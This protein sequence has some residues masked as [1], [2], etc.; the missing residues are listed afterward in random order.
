[1]I[2]IVILGLLAIAILIVRDFF[3][4]VLPAFAAEYD[5]YV[6]Q[7]VH[8]LLILFIS[9]VAAYHL[10]LPNPAASTRLMQSVMLS[11]ILMLS[12]GVIA[13]IGIETFRAGAF[14]AKFA[15]V[16]TASACVIALCV[17]IICWGEN[18]YPTLYD[19]YTR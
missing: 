9:A 16:T 10:W 17:L 5:P 3:P 13:P 18:R 12:G 7:S 15:S 4:G 14:D 11:V 8:Y 6:K 19:K 1:M 2:Q